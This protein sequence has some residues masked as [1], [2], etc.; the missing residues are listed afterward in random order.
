M[1]LNQL[2]YFVSAAENL[3][4]TKAANQCF[5][6]QTAMTQQIKSLEKTVGVP[7]FVR[8]NHHVELTP[9]GKV[10]LKEA[11][12]ILERSDEALRLARLVTDGT[13]GEINVGYISGFGSSDAPAVLNSFH[14]AY[15][16]IKMNISRDTMSGLVDS[17]NRGECD[18]AFTVA[19]PPDQAR[20]VN[21]KYIRSYP[22]MAV[23]DAGHPLS[24]KASLKYSDLVDENFIIMQPSARARDEMEETVLIYKR[25]GFVPN[26]VAFE[27]EPETILLMIS[28]GMGIA[29]LPE[30]IVRHHHKNP[31]LKIVPIEKNDGTS[32]TLDFE[33]AWS[34]KNSN[35]V[36]DTLLGWIDEQIYTNI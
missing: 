15:P 4:F 8:D 28:L 24:N 2:E 20:H 30:Y 32:E 18:V 11:R 21:H 14:S 12:A 13:H 27:R 10:Y 6:S 17:L 5:I 33:I 25:G 36:V 16:N 3:N 31:G 35:T 23:L 34:Q 19:L 9:A 1:N 29:L 7:L 22:L 26:I